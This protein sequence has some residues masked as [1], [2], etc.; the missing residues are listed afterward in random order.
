MHGIES[1]VGLDALDR[2]LSKERDGVGEV[3]FGGL[4]RST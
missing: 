2:D 4:D 1:S 3:S